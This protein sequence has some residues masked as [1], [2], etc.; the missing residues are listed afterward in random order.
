MPDFQEDDVDMDVGNIDQRESVAPG[1]TED[2]VLA[3]TQGQ[4]AKRARPDYVQYAKKAKR[5]D[6]KRLKENIWTSLEAGFVSFSPARER[7]F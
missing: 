6:V 4:S 7:H 3:A 1:L 2:E 5:V